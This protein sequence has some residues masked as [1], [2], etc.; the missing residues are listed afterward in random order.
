MQQAQVNIIVRLASISAMLFLTAIS[1]LWAS[2][3]AAARLPAHHRYLV[4]QEILSPQDERLFRRGLQIFRHDWAPS[5]TGFSE[6]EG[7]GPLFNRFSCIACHPGGGRG[8]PPT[9]IGQSLLSSILF[10]KDPNGIY[11][12]IAGRPVP[13]ELGG[14]FHPRAIR[15][16]VAEGN[17][18]VEYEEIAGR[19]PDGQC[20]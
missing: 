16:V 15:P 14:Q 18:Q 5:G 7:L 9:G 1:D 3:D 8:K 2:D 4:P 10:L 20:L 6:L 11:D 19:Y 12:A 13:E 17:L